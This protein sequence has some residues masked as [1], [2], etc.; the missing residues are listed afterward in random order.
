MTANPTTDDAAFIANLVGGNAGAAAADPFTAA[1]DL[2]ST[3]DTIAATILGVPLRP[4]TL[5]DALLLMRCKNVYFT[6]AA[7]KDTVRTIESALEVMVL[8]RAGEDSSALRATFC[9]TAIRR[10]AVE[11]FAATLPAN[12]MAGIITAVDA[13]VSQ[14]TETQVDA[15]SPTENIGGSGPGNG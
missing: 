15:K 11:Q 10:N 12:G 9:D 6:I 2:L 4:L 14:A 1:D 8:C 13:Y 3:T 5:A 7:E